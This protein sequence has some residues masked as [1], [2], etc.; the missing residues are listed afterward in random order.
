M[1]ERREGEMQEGKKEGEKKGKNE[2]RKEIQ[3][4]GNKKICKFSMKTANHWYAFEK[5]TGV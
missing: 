2:R 1:K 3:K 5:L 4:K